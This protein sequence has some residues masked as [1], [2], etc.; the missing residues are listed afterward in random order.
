MSEG[1]VRV[2]GEPAI[3]RAKGAR[4][5]IGHDYLGHGSEEFGP[6]EGLRETHEGFA[7]NPEYMQRFLAALRPL[8]PVEQGRY[9]IFGCYAFN[10]YNVPRETQDLDITFVADAYEP[11]VEGIERAG[12]PGLRVERR[13]RQA[14]IIQERPEKAEKI[15]DIFIAEANPVLK[16]ALRDPRGT[17]WFKVPRFGEAW[18]IAPEGIVAAKYYAASDP[19]RGDR[20]FADVWDMLSTFKER[21]NQPIDMDLLRKLVAAVPLPRAAQIF[22]SILGEI[23]AG[24]TPRFPWGA[25]DE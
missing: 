23:A 1:T 21:E 22:E 24:R 11:I 6:L 12:L 16:A 5:S 25:L 20:R 7:V 13:P 9:C 4:I 10:C 8:L 15:G 3:E 17:R 19:A 18:V 14:L 2:G